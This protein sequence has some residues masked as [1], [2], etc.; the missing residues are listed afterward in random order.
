MM[1]SRRNKMLLKQLTAI[2][3]TFLISQQTFA[4]NGAFDFGFS[5]ITRGMAGSGA[6][7]PQDS[8]SAALNPAGMAY[9][10]KQM[11]IGAAIYFPDMHYSA[12]N[13]SGPFP[14][15]II[16]APGKHKSDTSIFLLPDF[17]YNT[18]I[19]DKSTLGFSLYSLGGF[20]A[21]FKNNNSATI[22]PPPVPPAPPASITPPGP[23]GGGNLKS[24][25]KQAVAAF[26]YARKFLNDRASWGV[27]LL[28][29]IQ[30][31]TVSG[32]QQLGNAGL[33][34]NPTHLSNKGTNYSV[35][36]GVRVGFIFHPFRQIAVSVA[37]QPKIYMSHLHDYA[38][39]LP[40]NGQFDMP[41]Y[42]N[43]GIAIHVAPNVV[44][45]GDIQKIWYKD[46]KAYGNTNAPLIAGGACIAG[47]R[48]QCLGGG[49]GAGFGWDNAVIIKVGAQWKINPH[50][51]VRAGYNRSNE[52]LPSNQ[53]ATNIVTPGAVVQNLYTVG[54]THT[55][56]KKDALNAFLVFIPEQS[57]TAVNRYSG[58]GQTTTVST[59]GIGFGISWTRKLA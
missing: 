7:L 19:N 35:G 6:A 53:G 52:V 26:T 12:S 29:G 54:A 4:V 42:G 41:P 39:L 15:G 44:F 13:P 11:D 33:S 58:V 21:E 32:L 16:I 3:A 40:N 56:N 1:F 57:K 20:G 45:T 48:S 43:I 31:L 24:D 38:G 25:L 2:C 49:N 50:W 28:V 46:V 36:A 55:L 14:P 34:N 47:D 59:S 10:G 27:S 30:A 51:I 9:V 8:L 22:T 17:G 5:E 37:Y 18:K 23:F